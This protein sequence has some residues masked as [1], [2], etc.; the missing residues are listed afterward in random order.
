MLV[1][2]RAAAGALSP[3]VFQASDTNSGKLLFVSGVIITELFYHIPAEK[4]SGCEAR[5]ENTEITL[6]YSRADGII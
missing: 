5:G 1:F 3:P 6:H 4:A 2:K